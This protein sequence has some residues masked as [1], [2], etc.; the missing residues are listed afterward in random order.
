M[1]IGISDIRDESDR[2]G[3]R[4]V[5]ELKKDSNSELVISNLYKKTTLQTNFGAIFLALIEG[6]P[7]QLNL[8]KYLN[9][10]LEF[11]EE[12]IRKRTFYFLKNTLEKLEIS[13]GLSKATKNIRKVIEIIEESENS[14][15]AKSKLIENFFLSEKQANSVLDMPLKK[16][17][18]LEKKQIDNE[19]KNLEEKK[20][21]FQKLLNER[22]LL[23]KLLIE[24]L[25]ILKKKYNVIRK[26]KIIK[27]INQNEELETLNNQILE[28]F[29]NKKTKLYIDNRLYLKRM[30]LGNYKKSFEVVNKTIDNKNI[31][32]FICNIEKNIKLIGIT[33]TGKVF[34]ID[35]ESS[36]NKDCKLDNKILGSI[37][38]NEIINF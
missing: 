12:T 33:N 5:I 17:T 25:L 37:H 21:Y 10:F 31:Q 2:D 27:N 32:K 29:I 23:L 19:I 3:M 36:I 7:V 24:E 22:E 4:I 9:Y 34:P 1:G 6:K 14:V 15:E 16:L 30:I 8:K 11:R 38:P 28:D 18:N 20:N 35:W 13:E 26:T